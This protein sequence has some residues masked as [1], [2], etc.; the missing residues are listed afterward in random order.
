MKILITA[1]PEIPVP[2]V[3][4]GGIERIVD[5]LVK[6]Y[7]LLGHEVHLLAHPESQVSV[8]LSGWKGKESQNQWDTFKNMG[9]LASIFLTNKFD[10]VHSFSRLAYLFPLL[11]FGIPKIMSYQREPSIAQISKAHRLA[12]PGSL[13]FT[14]CSKYIS[15]KISK[16]ATSFPIHNFT[17]MEKFSFVPN[18]APD[19]PLVFLGRIE[20]IKGTDL[21]IE[22][23]QKTN[24]KL[25]I[26]G[27]IPLDKKDFFDQKIAPHLNNDIQY[28][29]QVNDVQ[30]NELLGKCSAFLMPITWEEPFGIVMAEAMACG[31]PVIGFRRGSVPEVVDHGNNGF[32]CDDVDGM[33]N[34]VN[35]I[36]ILNRLSVRLTVENRFSATVIATQYLNLYKSLITS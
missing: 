35:Q 16:V 6:E 14:G 30:K 11:K 3:H 20:P 23:A 12:K 31:T 15:D 19:A 7:T 28:I 32:V 24:R 17:E 1:D 29:G 9:Q 13:V 26:A 22:V 33:I 18:V 2:P 4:Y 34:Y 10:V 25:I 36:D 27:N 8:K 21:A 5:A